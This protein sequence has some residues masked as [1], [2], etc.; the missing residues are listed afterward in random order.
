MH[1]NI[2]NTAYF[3]F[4]CDVHSGSHHVIIYT[5]PSRDFLHG[6]KMRPRNKASLLWCNKAT[7]TDCHPMQHTVSICTQ[8]LIFSE[9][10]HVLAFSRFCFDIN[11]T[12]KWRT[13]GTNLLAI[14]T[15]T[16]REFILFREKMFSLTLNQFAKPHSTHDHHSSDTE[17]CG[18]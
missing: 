15:I 14:D 4:N 18:I 16:L 11:Q 13:Y 3:L 2:I 1:E 6:C 10:L 12:E 5:R 7:T 17:Y 8:I 9:N